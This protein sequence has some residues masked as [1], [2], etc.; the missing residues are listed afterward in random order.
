MA[1]QVAARLQGDDYQHL[2][3]W[4]QILC[5]GLPGGDVHKVEVESEGSGNVDDVVVRRRAQ[6]DEYLQVKFSVDASKPITSEWLTTARAPKGKSPL[7]RFAMSWAQLKS[8]GLKPQMTLFTNRALDYDDPIL[9]LRDGRRGVTGP[10]LGDEIAG[11][12]AR[13][14]LSRW[15]THAGLP[16]SELLDLL[17]HLGFRTDQGSANG[18]FEAVCDR[19]RSVGLRASELD[20]EAG[21]SAVRGWVK[22][23]VR[24]IDRARFLAEVERRQLAGGQAHSTLLVEA[25]DHA[26]WPDAAQVCLNWV[27]LFSGAEPRARRQLRDPSLWSS[28]LRPEMVEAARMLKASGADRVFVRGYMRLPLWFLVGAELPDTRG[29]HVA[30]TQRGAWW[31]S[32]AARTAFQVSVR[33]TQ[34]DQGE[35]LGIGLSVTNSLEEDV[36]A[37]CRGSRLPISRFLD[38]SPSGGPGA[39]AIG[40]N[41]A[42]LGWA[43]ETREAVRRAARECGARRIHLFLSGPGGGALMLGHIWNRLPPTL[44]YEDLSPGYSATFELP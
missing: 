2:Y 34:V 36:L 43:H 44:V 25:I 40:G 30:C 7:Q 29:H 41:D 16:E 38:I 1:N 26:P 10:R 12:P 9:K 28:K 14:Q 11:S 17:A 5:L 24:E 3:A 42:A 8:K 13:K 37:Y 22:E 23:G 15:A 20:A 4:Y 32:D 18:L 19:M 6:A 21:I 27:D 35:D 31:T 33:S 39:A